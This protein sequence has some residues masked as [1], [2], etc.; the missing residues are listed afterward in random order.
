MIMQYLVSFITMKDGFRVSL[1]CL[2]HLFLII[3]LICGTIAYNNIKDNPAAVIILLLFL[4][5]IIMLLAAVFTSKN[6]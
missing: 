6:T 3:E 5:Q 1:N 4:L 2:N